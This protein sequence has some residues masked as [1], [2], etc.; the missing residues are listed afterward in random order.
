MGNFKMQIACIVFIIFIGVIYHS[1]HRLH[2]QAHKIYNLMLGC[3][4]I[5]LIF[6]IITVYTVNHLDS[7]PRWFN[8]FA[9]QIFI[10][11]L[12]LVLFLLFFYIVELIELPEKMGNN[13]KIVKILAWIPLAITGIVIVFGDMKYMETPQGNYSYGIVANTCY[14]NVAL[15]ILMSLIFIFKY[16]KN[17]EKGKRIVIYV[18]LSIE[19][20]ISVYQAIYPTA[21]ISALGITLVALSIFITIENPDRVLLEL[22]RQEKDRADQAN[23]A[24]SDFL[25]KM[26]HEIRT[27]INAILGMD[28]M[29]MRETDMNKIKEYG[30]NI[31]D[32]GNTLLS[33]I[34]EILD[35]SKIEAGK[36]E[37]I[38]VKYDISSTLIDLV[39]VIALKAKSKNL[40]L[41]FDI[42]RDIPYLLYGDEIKF[43]QIMTN[44]LSNAVKYTNTGVITISIQ[45]KMVN[46]FE[47]LLMVSIQDTGIGIKEKNIAKLTN[48]FQRF[49][50]EKNKDIEGT[51]L[52]LTIT[53]NLIGI[54]GGKLNVKSVYGE[55]SEFSFEIKQK[56]LDKTPMGDFGEKFTKTMERHTQY[57][58]SFVAPK[59]KILVVDDNYMNLMVVKGLLKDIEIHIDTALSGEECLKL[60]NVNKYHMIFLDHMMPEMDGIETLKQIRSLEEKV[61]KALPLIAL[62]ANAISGSKQMYLDEGFDDYLSKPI[63]PMKLEKV[64]LKYLP[65]EL[66]NRC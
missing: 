35:L 12:D 14:V 53:K 60:M 31:Q 30:G 32:A 57:Q 34:N 52:G 65:E 58:K 42:A 4:F 3:I 56:V 33:I 20:A 29:I 21:L 66:I 15:H 16:W 17:I 11:T 8:H 25:A 9:H 62:T 46:E 24:K 7:V 1:V 50:R 19:V 10:G 13:F 27:P 5:N 2:T 54:M 45:W 61:G 28:E 37:I 63:E 55:G 43:K 64:I 44:L 6:D 18:T 59:G 48:S 38:P 41:E 36:M 47:L 40:R 49:D 23:Q 51:G 26:S 22:Y 39:N